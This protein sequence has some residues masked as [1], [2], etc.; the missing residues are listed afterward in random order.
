MI[1]GDFNFCFDRDFNVFR[2]RISAWRKHMPRL[3]IC[4]QKG[5]RGIAIHA[6]V[7]GTSQMYLN[8]SKNVVQ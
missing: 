7:A 1:A 5:L 8:K 2:E 4:Y 3:F 6:C